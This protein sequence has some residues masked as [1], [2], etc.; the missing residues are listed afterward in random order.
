MK[1]II[2]AVSFAVLAVP[3]FAFAADASAP[4]EKA[5]FDRMLPNVDNTVAA[6]RADAS[7]GP[8][9]AAGSSLATGV[10]AQD[11]N[12]ISPAE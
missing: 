4:Y 1:R 5:Q 8:S 12:F 7:A 10:W 6:E 3:A 2:T 9:S 11:H